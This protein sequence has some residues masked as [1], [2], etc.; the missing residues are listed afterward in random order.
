MTGSEQSRLIPWSPPPQ[1]HITLQRKMEDTWIKLGWGR[2]WEGGKM[3]V[4]GMALGCRQVEK[5]LGKDSKV[6]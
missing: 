2:C 5:Q 6:N 1:K 3:K 4:E